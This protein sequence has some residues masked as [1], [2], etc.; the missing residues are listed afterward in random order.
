MFKVGGA[1]MFPM[2]SRNHHI[3]MLGIKVSNPFLTSNLRL[4]IRSYAIFA[5]QKR[6]DEQNP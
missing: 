4:P 1:A 2:M 3:V 6:P 5:K